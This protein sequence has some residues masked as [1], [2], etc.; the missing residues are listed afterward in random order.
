MWSV[1]RAVT[2]LLCCKTSKPHLMPHFENLMRLF[3]H[4][5]FKAKNESVEF[6]EKLILGYS[7]HRR[8]NNLLANVSTN[9]VQ[10]KI[11]SSTV[12]PDPKK[13]WGRTYTTN[14]IQYAHKSTVHTHIPRRQRPLYNLIKIQ[15][16][17]CTQV[18]SWIKQHKKRTHL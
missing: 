11:I 8:K 17:I 13:Q 3:I 10:E 12:F 4:L 7:V 9:F 15:Q 5:T 6:K 16:I 18:F 1:V 2:G 14:N